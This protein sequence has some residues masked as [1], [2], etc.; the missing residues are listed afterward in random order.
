MT[1]ILVYYKLNFCYAKTTTERAGNKERVHIGQHYS[2]ILACDEGLAALARTAEEV[3]R[4][5]HMH[6][7][8]RVTF[9]QKKALKPLFYLDA[10]EA[11]DGEEKTAQ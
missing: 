6:E 4:F 7:S 10:N 11:R 2:V 5:K 1:S 3:L 8:V 9:H